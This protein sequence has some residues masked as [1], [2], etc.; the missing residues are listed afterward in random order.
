LG[1]STKADKGTYEIESVARAC[2][3]LNCFRG[4][5]DVLRL[6][7]VVARTGLNTATAFRILR[8]LEKYGLIE[9][10]GRAGYRSAVR[11]TSTSRYRFGYA[12]QGEDS[13]FA[14]EWTE[15]IIQAA[16]M[17]NVELLVYD[18]G[19]DP[20]KTL[21][22]ADRMIR[23]KIDLAIEHQFNEQIAPI[24]SARFLE[25]KIPLIAMGAAHT[26]ATYFGGNN[27][28]AGVIGGRALGA[29]A[30]RHWKG[31]ADQLLLAGMS[32][33]GPLLRSRMTGVENGVREMLPNLQIVT[34]LEGSG[35]FGDTLDLVRKHLRRTRYRHILLG[36]VN[37]PCALGALRAFEE[38]GWDDNC[39]IVGQGGAV[40][41]RHELRR[42]H[43]HLIGTVAFFP[44]KY[45]EAIMR[46]A[47]DLLENRPVPS[48]VFTRH[49]LLTPENIDHYYPND[50]LLGRP[51]PA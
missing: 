26:G 33:A 50:V 17:E 36:A 3:L 15:S 5:E 1:K 34:H 41:A 19:Y 7:D 31:Q 11:T 23:E 18:N 40:E 47:F 20:E 39:A 44:E 45:G 9:R 16:R 13:A 46:I 2:Q 12:S 42:P 30:K 8:T 49:R 43:S 6:R 29:W 10:V 27:Y 22:N 32:M 24:L 28:Q 51:A 21:Q 35:H 38:A 14:Q 48:A 25:A 37:D 4:R